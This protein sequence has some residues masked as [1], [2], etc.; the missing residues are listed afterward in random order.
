M[1]TVIRNDIRR[2]VLNYVKN[3]AAPVKISNVADEI[4]KHQQL[5]SVSDADVRSIV[6]PM[7][8]TGKL[9]YAPGLRIT[10][11]KTTK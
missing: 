5:S 6:Q 10:V 11:G 2:E 9:S 7:I 8:V 1:S 3:S 4:R